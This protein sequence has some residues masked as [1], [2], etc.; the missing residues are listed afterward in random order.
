MRRQLVALVQAIESFNSYQQKIEGFVTGGST[1]AIA[2]A[3]KLD[4]VFDGEQFKLSTG[5]FARDSVALSDVFRESGLTVD[6]L[7]WAK[8]LA[9]MTSTLHI[10]LI[11]NAEG[12]GMYRYLRELEAQMRREGLFEPEEVQGAPDAG[13]E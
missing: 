6:E 5:L 3:T 1:V 9:E 10:T 12:K 7:R 11:G 13:K 4:T 8:Y 2:V